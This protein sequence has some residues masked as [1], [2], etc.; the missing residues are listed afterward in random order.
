MVLSYNFILYK[1]GIVLQY[2]H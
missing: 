1:D 2:H